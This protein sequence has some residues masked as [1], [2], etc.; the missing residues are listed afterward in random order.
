MQT[1]NKFLLLVIIVALV[2]ACSNIGKYKGYPGKRLEDE[3][4]ATI[5]GEN[6]NVG[7]SHYISFQEFYANIQKDKLGLNIKPAGGIDS[8]L[9]I[10][11]GEYIFFV[12]CVIDRKYDTSI[13]WAS[14][15]SGIYTNT[16]TIITHFQ[17]PMIRLAVEA[18]R[19][20]VLGCDKQ[21]DG[22]Y[23]AML[24]YAVSI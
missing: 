6:I 21:S 15:G 7:V 20:Y 16:F 2:T 14:Y 1:S 8:D 5:R 18:G 22:K 23:E 19:F 12:R 9:Q 10:L 24:R 3:R 11:P 13:N 17:T 4:I